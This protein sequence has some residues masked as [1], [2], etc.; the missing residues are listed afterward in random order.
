MRKW[1]YAIATVVVD[2]IEL[3]RD[4]LNEKGRDGWE[5]VTIEI[6]NIEQPGKIRVVGKVVSKR[7]IA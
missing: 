5:V 1:E 4:Y 6:T 2:K 3:L 7:E